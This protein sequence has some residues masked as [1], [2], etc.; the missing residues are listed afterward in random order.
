MV[1]KKGSLI[2]CGA[3]LF[4]A[5]NALLLLYLWGR[6]PIGR[7][8]EGGGAE[9]G[10]KEEWGVGIGKGGLAEEVIRLA[11]E[12]EIQLETQKRL[13]KQI[14]SN[15]AVWAQQ[16]DV[17]K[18]ETED[19]K[20]VKQEVVHQPQK[21]SLPLKDIVDD[22]DQTRVKPTQK[23]VH[24]EASDSKLEQH[25]AIE[26][27]ENI[28]ENNKLATS[29]S[30]P[31]VVIPILVIACDRVTVKRSLDRLI[32]YRPSPQLH[33]IIVS[34]D[35]GHA[36]TARVIGSYGDQVT[37][38]TQP[39]LSDIR[40]RPE[41]RKFQ[42]YYKISRHY[43]WALDQVFNT[44]STVVIVE[45]D[46][47]VAPDFFEYFR[48]L[49]PI[50]HADPTLWCVS[51]WN[52]NGRDALVDPSKAELLYRTDFFPGLG[53]MMLKEMWDELEPK[54]PSAFWDDWMRQPD[55]RKERSCIRPEVSRTITFGRKGVS[56][57]QFF[58][59]YLRYIK[60][61]TEF[62][63][64]TKQD[65]SYL[66]KENYDEKLL[67]EVYSAQLVKIEELQQ[68]GSLRG[69]GPFRVQYSS[70]D[71]FKVFA[72]NLGVMDDL[73]SGVPRTGYRGV[74]NFLYRGRRVF[75]APPEGWTQ[76]DVSWS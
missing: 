53:W 45:D 71:T 27:K 67:K 16:K 14:E 46:L 4:V 59:Q 44:F 42:G 3:F 60:L 39:D 15:R 9:P 38:I 57:G 65:L 2:L 12:V 73:K 19:T 76:Y 5:W 48:A 49:Y 66:L 36:E 37:H 55:Q 51:A 56:L 20:E 8:G 31:E 35:C 28:G 75:L 26:I 25:Q 29:I 64:F 52:D 41:H 21:L 22:S 47:E 32:Q 58:D 23:P 62:V 30:T 34:Q 63:P 7:L 61:N 72:R 68:G 18:R 6:P 33:P 70:R 1:R 74:V 17:G 43:H 54:W 50:L 69:P 24:T 11:E 10:G 13:L 40:V